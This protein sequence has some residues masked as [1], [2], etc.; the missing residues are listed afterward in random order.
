LELSYCYWITKVS[1]LGNVHILNLDGC[2]VDDV[3][4]LN[5][6]YEL[7]VSYF[8]GSS[9]VGLENVQKLYSSDSLAICDISMLKSVNYYIFL[10][11]QRLL[12]FMV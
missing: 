1:A 9:L 7:H 11:A 4:A 6:V 2:R 10:A 12:I 8:Q 5:N 3:T